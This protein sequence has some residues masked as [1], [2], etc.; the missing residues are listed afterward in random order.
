MPTRNGEVLANTI[1]GAEF[2]LWPGAGHLY[3]TDEP[4]ADRYI[5][6]FLVRHTATAAEQRAS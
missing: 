1:P 4:E 5:R 6:Q 3:T 2:K